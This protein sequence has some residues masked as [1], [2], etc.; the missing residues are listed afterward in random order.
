MITTQSNFHGRY[1]LVSV[2]RNRREREQS[3]PVLAWKQLLFSTTYCQDTRLRRVDDRS[4]VVDAPEH[5]QIWY[6]ESSS[7]KQLHESSVLAGELKEPGEGL[8]PTWNSCGCNFPSRARLANPVTSLLIVNNPLESASK[9]IGVIR[10][11][12]V[13]TATDTSTVLFFLMK[14]SM[15][16]EFASGTRRQDRALALIMKSLIESLCGLAS[17]FSSLAMMSL[18]FERTL[19][20]LQ[21]DQT[22]RTLK[23]TSTSHP[24]WSRW[25]GNSEGWCSLILLDVWQL[26]SAYSS[27]GCLQIDRM[28]RSFGQHRTEELFPAR[29]LVGEQHHQPVCQKR[30]F[31]H[32]ECCVSGLLK[33]KYT[34]SGSLNFGQRTSVLR[35]QF[36]SIRSGF[37]A[38]CEW[39][40][41]SMLL[42]W[43]NSR[44]G[45]L[46]DRY[47]L[48]RFLFGCLF[49]RNTLGLGGIV[50][51]E[52]LERRDIA[53]FFNNYA[54]KLQL[55][56]C[57]I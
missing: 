20:E 50:W 51:L 19:K 21:D 25:S 13:L 38:I 14:V 46:L 26:S 55:G 33:S 52:I 1:L 41:S 7:L 22:C 2:E 47:I 3:L 12:S 34:W 28:A 35:C 39:G 56:S 8:E 36:F 11:R 10:P 44:F 23:L 18:S 48:P 17:P 4:K 5:S 29:R 16:K 40:Q 6:S 27:V 45:L 42:L 9:T 30:G 31:G 32:L 43:L 24:Q 37:K 49:R 53:F 54:K 15:K 57:Q